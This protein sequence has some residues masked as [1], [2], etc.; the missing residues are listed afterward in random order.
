MSSRAAAALPALLFALLAVACLWLYWPGTSGPSVLDD[1]SNL[2][3]LDN[4]EESREFL[5]DVVRSN[6]SGPLG[7][8]LSMLVFSLEKIYIDAGVAGTKRFNL[9]L[10]LFMA[11]LVALFARDVLRCLHY[12]RAAALAVLVAGLWLLTPLFISTVLYTIQRMAQLSALLSLLA[13]WSY[14]RAR[15]STGNG[16]LGWGALSLLS[17]VAAPLAKE[18]G[19]LAL[20]L[21]MFSEWCLL[22]YRG[23]AG[24]QVRWVHT[25]L[26]AFGVVSVGAVLIWRPELVLGGYSG[27]DFSRGERLLTEGRVVWFYVAQLLWA[28]PQGL[29]LYQ[30]GWPVSR[31]WLQPWV[32]LPALVGWLL[33][34]ALV[35]VMRRDR[36]WRPM[37]FGFGFF[38]TAHSMESTIFPLELVFEHRNYLPAVGLFIA[39][40]A[41]LA[42]LWQRWPWLRSWLLAALLLMLM[43]NA[44]LLGSEVQIWSNEF[45]LN[46]VSLNRFPDSAR[47]NAEMARVL[48][49]AG[50]I[51]EAVVMLDRSAELN[52][53]GNSLQHSLRGISLYC[54]GEQAI[55]AAVIAGLSATAQDFRID[56][57][58]NTMTLLVNRILDGGCAATD[59]PL[60][61]DRL[62]ELLK[63]S[64]P[65]FVAPTI[66]VSLAILENYLQRYPQALEHI[67]GLLGRSPGNIR[68]LMMKLYFTSVLGQGAEHQRV[69]EE[70]QQLQAQ[71][72]L[73]R[74]QHYNL[75]LFTQPVNQ[76]AAIAPGE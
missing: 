66:Y 26:L 59:F 68:A 9:V 65:R 17:M 70:L 10:H 1:G 73:N 35:F 48:G 38:V 62:A 55:P 37:A 64:D 15:L 28:D 67:N 3:A 21:I 4:L 76:P 61:A 8:P 47:A 49:Q 54:F 20:P 5:P 7:R 22:H 53:T 57:T 12:P 34:L 32:T 30:D 42:G 51:D 27:R 72:L 11:A 71:G 13:V 23:R 2:R 6:A 29:G 36:R 63:V 75:E 41:A 60:L 19:L 18:N 14:L 74:Q 39:L 44:L 56:A 31:G 24:R 40:V 33:V 43:R 69:A 58:S 50:A 25:L 16:W 46:A 52:G 45:V